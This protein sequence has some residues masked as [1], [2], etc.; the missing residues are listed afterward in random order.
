MK[1]KNTLEK[2]KSF[3][4]RSNK[5]RQENT[6]E[7][8]PLTDEL[9]FEIETNAITNFITKFDFLSLFE[10]AEQKGLMD[11]LLPWLA[12]LFALITMLIVIFK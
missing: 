9:K 10:Q 11:L 5:I 1:K 7:F 12:P 6:E 3:I 2:I 4:K 8:V